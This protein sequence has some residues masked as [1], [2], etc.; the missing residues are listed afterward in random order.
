MNVIG[1]GLVTYDSIEQVQVIKAPVITPFTLNPIHE[2]DSLSLSVSVSDL[3]FPLLTPVQW[4]LNGDGVFGDATGTPVSLSWVQLTAL[5]LNQGAGSYPIA[6]R[7]TSIQGSSDFTTTLTILATPP[8]LTVTAPP[9]AT[10]GQPY[11]INFSAF[12]IGHDAVT[13]WLICWGDGSAQQVFGSTATSASHIYG[14]PSAAGYAISVQA[15][16]QNFTTVY[17]NTLKVV[18][19]D[20][21]PT[22]SQFVVPAT[23]VEGSAITLSVTAAAAG[24]DPTLTYAWLV[25]RNGQ[26][27]ATSTSPSFTFTPGSSIIATEA[28]Q[29]SVTVTDIYGMSTQA[30]STI[31]VADVAPEVLDV[32]IGALAFAGQP[33]PFMVIASDPGGLSS[34]VTYKYDF[35]NSGAFATTSA[36]STMNYTF[37]AAGTYTVNVM[38]VDMA[39]VASTPFSIQVLVLPVVPIAPVSGPASGIEGVPYTLALGPLQNPPGAADPITSWSINWG[40]G[41]VDAV[42]GSASSATHT[43]VDHAAYVISATVTNVDGTYAAANTLPV[44]IAAAAPVLTI[45]GPAAVNE[46]PYALN[47]ASA[48]TFNDPITELD[49]Q[50]GGWLHPDLLWRPQHRDPYLRRH[51]HTHHHGQ[52]HQQPGQLCRQLAGCPNH[53]FASHD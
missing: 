33:T 22:I 1:A 17:P 43:Y 30:H 41:T 34:I 10:V 24:S 7:A 18:V 19:V 5:G 51:G 38:A 35:D 20:A 52:R 44:S 9:T 4:D 27:F 14:V 23:G 8:V 45:S 37:A 11:T 28:Y 48:N 42:D 46:G 15:V 31:T 12:E 13:Q 29:V 16:D 3:G 32:Q 26:T 40:D 39:G 47:L 53:Q 49:D 2:G 21:A 25:T 50:L 6:V 36:S